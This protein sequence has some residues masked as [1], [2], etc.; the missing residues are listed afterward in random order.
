V[1]FLA[2]DNNLIY[3]PQLKFSRNRMQWHRNSP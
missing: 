3:P 1:V 2:N